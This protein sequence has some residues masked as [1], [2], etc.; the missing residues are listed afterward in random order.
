MDTLQDLKGLLSMVSAQGRKTPDWNAG[1]WL[2]DGELVIRTFLMG[3]QVKGNGASGPEVIWK[4]ENML[5]APK[6]KTSWCSHSCY[7]ASIH[8]HPSY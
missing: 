3:N 5:F 8:H 4:A 7:L 2:G 6:S 1:L